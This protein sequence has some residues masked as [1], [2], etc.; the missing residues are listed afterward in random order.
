MILEKTM[1]CF[2]GVGVRPALAQAQKYT[3]SHAPRIINL[4][5]IL[6]RRVR[7]K[8]SYLWEKHSKSS[9]E[10]R[11]TAEPVSPLEE[12]DDADGVVTVAVHRILRRRQNVSQPNSAQHLMTKASLTRQQVQRLRFEI[13]ALL[14]PRAVS[15]DSLSACASRGTYPKAPSWKAPPPTYQRSRRLLSRR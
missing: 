2:A 8:S 15:C 9:C 1:T 6:W 10:R 12:N 3:L 11:H 7:S 5:R 13:P 4:T 14:L